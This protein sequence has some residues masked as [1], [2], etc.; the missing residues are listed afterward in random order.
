[1]KDLKEAEQLQAVFL[2]KHDTYFMIHV[3]QE[4]VFVRLSGQV[5]LERSDFELFGQRFLAS[6]AEVRKAAKVAAKL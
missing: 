4:K 5:Y 2:S 1:V 3:L 6:L